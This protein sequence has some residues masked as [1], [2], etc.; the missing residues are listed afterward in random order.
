[1]ALSW[2]ATCRPPLPPFPH[3]KN[4]QIAIL[5]PY[6]AQSSETGLFP[7]KDIQTTPSKRTALIFGPN[8]TIETF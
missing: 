5:V 2:R 6:V 8:P 7:V 3:T 1:M 4:D